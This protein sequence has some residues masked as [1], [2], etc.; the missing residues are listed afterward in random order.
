MH[1]MEIHTAVQYRLPIT[2]VLFNNNAHAMCVTRE[3]LFYGDRYSY[4]ELEE[5]TDLIKRTLQAVP[6]VSTVTRTGLLEERIYLNYSQERLAAYGVL[7]SQIPQ[8]L[9][10][11][12]ITL[13]GGS[14]E[15][16]NKLLRV[17]P[18]GEF[19]SERDIGDGRAQQDHAEAD[20][21]RDAP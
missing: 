13:P 4:K 8:I 7:P 17:D 21:E 9:R 2:F 18:S 16:G 1:G 6:N 15:S 11:R 12:N 14:I 10:A 20:G 19:T 3:Q 5:F